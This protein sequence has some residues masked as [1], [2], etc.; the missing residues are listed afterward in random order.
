MF[1]I[2]CA[3]KEELDEILLF[4]E[5]IS[6]ENLGHIKIFR[7]IINNIP[8]VAA[9]CGV[10][11]VNAA[12][13]TY[14]LILN[15]RPDFILNV[16]VAGSIDKNLNILDAV[17]ADSAIQHDFDISAFPNRKKGEISGIDS[18]K[19]PCTSWIVE[20]LFDSAKK[21]E[22]INFKV[23]TVLTG[24]QFI[25]SK[26]KLLRLKNEFGG[27]A[28]DM[29][30]GSISQLCLMNKVDFGILRT[31]SD[32]ANDHSPIDFNTFVKKSSK[33]AANI[34]LNFTKLI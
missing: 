1:A 15:Y 5:N 19:M 6:C 16:G 25:N 31:I 33:N 26:E 12:M 23:G 21:I 10:G 13:C 4:M 11:K 22:N 2:I 30:A 20:K 17:V 9:L 3:M 24:D 29:E 7:G 14:G 18:V 27:L 34:I 32:N 28:C 8:C